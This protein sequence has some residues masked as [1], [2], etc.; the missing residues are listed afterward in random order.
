MAAS[1]GNTACAEPVLTGFEHFHVCPR[2]VDSAVR[3][4]WL[5]DQAYQMV[6]AGLTEMFGK[7]WLRS[8]EE[9]AML[10]GI[11]RSAHVCPPSAETA[12]NASLL[13][14]PPSFEGATNAWYA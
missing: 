3:M 12:R 14:E 5:S 11:G 7:L 10:Q 9:E 4:L 1:Q 6:P 13:L 8:V 2:S